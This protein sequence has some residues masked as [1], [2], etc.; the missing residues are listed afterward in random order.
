MDHGV[1]LR[2]PPHALVPAGERRVVDQVGTLDQHQEVAPLLR[3]DGAEADPAV[4]RRLDGRDLDRARERPGMSREAL[5]HHRVR[6][7]GERHHLEEREVDVLAAAV[8]SRAVPDGERDRRRVRAAE[9]FPEPAAGG[10]G[11]PIRR[12]ARRG[13]AAPRLER[14]LGRRPPAPRPAATEGR[15]GDERDAGVPRP[16]RLRIEPDASIAPG[17]R[18]STT[19]SA[20]VAS[21]RTRSRPAGEPRSTA[22]LRLEV[23]RKRNSTPSSSRPAAV[24]TRSSAAADRRAGLLDLEHVGAGVGQQLGAVRPGDLGRQVEDADAGERSRHSLSG[25]AGDRADDPECGRGGRAPCSCRAASSSP[26]P[27]ARRGRGGRW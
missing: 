17:P 3:R 1:H 14:E 7:H 24:P 6:R 12:A 2:R 27:W 15:D 13:R 16:H 8:A 18:L 9:P 11:R 23:L 19:M 21:S 22:A 5:P 10:E 25:R 26:R 20:P 4:A